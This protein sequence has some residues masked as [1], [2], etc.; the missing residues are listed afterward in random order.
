MKRV[1][2]NNRVKGMALLLAAMVVSGLSA[3]GAKDTGSTSGGALDQ[4]KVIR[5]GFQGSSLIRWLE[6]SQHFLEKEFGPDGIKIEFEQFS[7]GPPIIEGLAAGS[8]D[9]GSVGDM[10]IVTAVANGLPIQSIY[11]DGIDPN[12]NTLLIPV[13]STI[14]SVAEL[15]GKKVGA[16]VGSSGHHY[17]VLVLAQAGLTVD[18]VEIVNLGATDLGTA[19]ATNQIAAGTTWEPYGTIF[20]VNGSAKY[21]AKSAGVKQNTSTEIARKAF[22]EANPG[23]TARYLKVQLQL[24]DFV[25][26]DRPRAVRLIAEASGFKEA[27]LSTILV[28][29]FDPHFTD[30]DWDQ[31]TKTKQFLLDNDLINKDYDI[32]TLFTDKYLIEAEKLYAASKK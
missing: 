26:A 9:F 21:L 14:K 7:Y 31:M 11:K 17:L 24:A 10:P 12:S 4:A 13:N 23:I 27:D 25:Q 19:L 30:F 3:G 20:T 29:E 5:I 2:L 8:L 28:Q 15:K 18:D 6:D 16:S 32:R 1:L 22:I